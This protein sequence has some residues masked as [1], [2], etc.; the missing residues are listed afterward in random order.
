M[1]CFELETESDNPQKVLYMFM[2][3]D[4]RCPITVQPVMDLE[5]VVITNLHEA[6]IQIQI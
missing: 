2:F 1:T 3:I 4:K 5:C 6:R